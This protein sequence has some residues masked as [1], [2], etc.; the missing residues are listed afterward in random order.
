M[1]GLWNP[2][3]SLSRI[4]DVV[5]DGAIFDVA[6]PLQWIDIPEKWVGYRSRLTYVNGE[7]KPTR[8]WLPDKF[9]EGSP[10]IEKKQSL[11]NLEVEYEGK[12]YQATTASQDA[13]ARNVA[14]GEDFIWL[15]KDNSEVTLTNAKGKALLKLMT[16]KTTAIIQ[17][18]Q[19]DCK[20]LEDITADKNDER[21]F[22]TMTI[23]GHD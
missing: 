2:D 3:D 17:K 21:V 11:I 22:E 9:T 18:Y 1:K 20:E 8:W 5:E 12:T 23:R 10:A 7:I 14:H 13:L 15:P 16:D 4:F 6:P 19:A